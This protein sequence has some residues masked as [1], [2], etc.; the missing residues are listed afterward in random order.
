MPRRTC[1]KLIDVFLD[2]ATQIQVHSGQH[3]ARR[4]IDFYGREVIPAVKREP[5]AAR[6]A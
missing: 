6:A 3:D 5:G 2:G 1:P 4:A